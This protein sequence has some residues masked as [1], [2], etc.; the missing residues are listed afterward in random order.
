MA[1]SNDG[2]ACNIK[3]IRVSSLNQCPSAAEKRAL[4][5]GTIV[6]SPCLSV[7]MSSSFNLESVLLQINLTWVISI[8]GSCAPSHMSP[9]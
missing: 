7:S 8:S 9:M 3:D 6:S 1:N 4:Q 5:R 2:R